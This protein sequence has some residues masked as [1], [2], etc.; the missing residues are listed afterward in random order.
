MLAPPPARPF[1]NMAPLARALRSK[2]GPNLMAL[3][4]DALSILFYILIEERKY[5]TLL[6]VS[7]IYTL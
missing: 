5:Y 2:K 1:A 7:L 3:A 4:G 6:R